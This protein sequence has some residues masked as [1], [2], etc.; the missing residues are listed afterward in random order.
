MI[1]KPSPILGYGL[2]NIVHPIF[3]RVINRQRSEIL[4]GT[5]HFSFF[6]SDWFSFFE[7]CGWT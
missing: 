4:S 6:P 7:N 2:V 1:L 5:H 3:I